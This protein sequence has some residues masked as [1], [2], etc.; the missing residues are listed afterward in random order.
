[1]RYIDAQKYI[2]LDL[3]LVLGNYINR[4]FY[5]AIE[6]YDLSIEHLKLAYSMC[7]KLKIMKDI[8]INSQLSK[9]LN[10]LALWDYK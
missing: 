8:N 7:T 6:S 10:S 1:M 3:I 4:Q 5:Q 9:L 2:A